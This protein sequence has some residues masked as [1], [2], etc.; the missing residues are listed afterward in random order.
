ME[1]KIKGLAWGW[2][3]HTLRRPDRHVANRALDGNPQ[4]KRKRRRPRHTWR[5]TRMSGLE[6]R[7]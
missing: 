4:R 5:R 1:E 6:E 7:E 3:G 2:I